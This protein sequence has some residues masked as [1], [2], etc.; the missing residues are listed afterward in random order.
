MHVSTRVLFATST[1]RFS[2]IPKAT[3]S[4]DICANNRAR[5]TVDSVGRC[6]TQASKLFEI[7]QSPFLRVF[8]QNDALSQVMLWP[9][10]PRGYT[11]DA[12]KFKKAPKRFT[13][14]VPFR[15]TGRLVLLRI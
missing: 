15:R 12:E 5:G 13:G 6:I 11:A 14:A 1:L 2:R 3:S 7:C 4:R 10:L 8:F 9:Y